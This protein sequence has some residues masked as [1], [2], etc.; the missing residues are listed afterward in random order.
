MHG[1]SR[2]LYSYLKMKVVKT[3]KPFYSKLFFF[4]SSTSNAYMFESFALSRLREVSVD[5]K[6]YLVLG[7][8]H[9]SIPQKFDL[10]RWMYT[11]LK[12]K[13]WADCSKY[14]SSALPALYI[15]PS[16]RFFSVALRS[17]WK[18]ADP[19]EWYSLWPI[20]LGLQVAGVPLLVVPSLL[21][22]HTV[23]VSSCSSN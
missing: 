10:F 17:R 8:G 3:L 6:F 22:L 15:L 16:F 18:K 23:F 20:F 21:S 1:P 11:I 5:P 7:S 19:R 4:K 13:R 2:Q 14:P 9:N 12:V